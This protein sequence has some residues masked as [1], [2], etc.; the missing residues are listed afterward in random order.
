MNLRAFEPRLQSTALLLQ[1]R[2]SLVD[3]IMAKVRQSKPQESPKP[4]ESADNA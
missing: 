1:E 3:T 4:R 2:P